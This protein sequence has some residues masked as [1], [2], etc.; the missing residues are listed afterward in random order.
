MRGGEGEGEGRWKVPSMVGRWTERGRFDLSWD[1]GG[2]EKR[3]R[4]R[5]FTTLGT[6]SLPFSSFLWGIV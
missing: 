1:S 3:R 2:Q 4:R 6:R 5:G